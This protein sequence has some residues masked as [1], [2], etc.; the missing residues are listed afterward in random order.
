MSGNGSAPLVDMGAY[1]YA[2][3]GNLDSFADVTLPDFALFSLQWMATDCGN[4]NGADFTGD[5]SVLI[6]DAL[7]Q[8][9]NWLCGTGP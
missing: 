6:D 9:A 5:G 8:W 7:F 4:C 1:E 3:S 2:C